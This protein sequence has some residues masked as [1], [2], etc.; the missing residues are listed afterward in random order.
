MQDLELLADGIVN[1][2]LANLHDRK[3]VGDELDGIDEQVYA[4]MKAEL[5]A[6]VVLRLRGDLTG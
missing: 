5:K 4:E 3:G 1:E 2:V 6:L